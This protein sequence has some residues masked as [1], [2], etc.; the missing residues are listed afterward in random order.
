MKKILF[1]TVISASLGLTSPQAFAEH[2]D[3][4][5]VCVVQV[6]KVLHDAPH[7]K[8]EVEKLKAKFEADQKTIQTKQDALEKA[9]KDLK[10]NE[11]V[12]TAADKEKAE[13]SIADQR[14]QVIH[15]ATEFQQKLSTE[16]KNNYGC[17]V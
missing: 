4:T 15:D 7:V 17:R 11:V 9:V 6:A 2:D 5:N 12:M 3:D 10:K 14:Q 8:K 13:K 1:L 16:Q